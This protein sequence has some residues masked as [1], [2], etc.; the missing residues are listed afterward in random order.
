LPSSVRASS[1]VAVMDANVTTPDGHP[2]GVARI[3]S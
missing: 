1:R 3:P 2:S